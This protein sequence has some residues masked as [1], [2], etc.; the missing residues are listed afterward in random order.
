M[1]PTEHWEDM[2]EFW[3]CACTANL[4][5][6]RLP[7]ST[8]VHSVPHT[9]QIAS[10]HLQ[11][12]YDDL[13]VQ[14]LFVDPEEPHTVAFH[15]NWK[16]LWCVR[17]GSLLG[18]AEMPSVDNDHQSHHCTT[19]HSHHHE[20]EAPKTDISVCTQHHDHSKA[21]SEEKMDKLVNEILFRNVKLDKHM[22]KT[23]TV[24]FSNHRLE[25]KISC[26]I[27]AVISIS[28]SPKILLRDYRTRMPA[29]I[30]TVLGWDSL[31]FSS[32]DPLQPVKAAYD[33]LMPSLRLLYSV[34]D[35]ETSPPPMS[36]FEILEYDKISLFHLSTL[37]ALRNSQLPPTIARLGTQPVSYLLYTPP[38]DLSKPH[39]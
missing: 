21:H 30:L 7:R 23:D 1:L 27:L 11:L 9:V 39:S 26:D 37:L 6:N 18:Q 32:S 28:G 25:T 38:V 22:I 17:C 14:S 15:R 36:D 12:H 29:I 33:S 19:S 34:L 2:R 20:I 10:S 3:T 35:K 24:Y 13:D 8:I 5:E 31:I 4:F 16:N